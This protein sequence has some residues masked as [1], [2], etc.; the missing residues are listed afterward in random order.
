MNKLRQIVLNL[1]PMSYLIRI[2]LLN[3]THQVILRMQTYIS[4]EQ[5]YALRITAVLAGLKEGEFLPVSKL[6]ST[7]SISKNFAA[8]I[9]HKLKSNNFI[10]AYQGKYG[11]VCLSKKPGM[12]TV[13]DILHCIGFKIKINQCLRESYQCS[14]MSMCK[15]HHVFAR[16][17]ARLYE[18]FR[19]MKI[20]DFIID[21]I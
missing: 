12:I 17:E 15:F 5:D 16:Q 4:R 3:I 2:V 8:R 10:K 13:F 1:T 11:G 9:V 19:L 6:A 18:E 20:S 14:I 7:L 21:T